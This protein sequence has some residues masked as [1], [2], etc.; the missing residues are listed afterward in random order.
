M[1]TRGTGL[2]VGSSDSAGKFTVYRNAVASWYGPG[3]YGNGVACG[4][5]LSPSTIGVANKTLPC[6][7]KVKF[8]YHGHSVTA[9]VIDRGPYS[10]NREF[11]LTEATKNKLHFPGV[12]TLRPRSRSAP[13]ACE[14][15]G[16]R[17]ALGPSHAWACLDCG[18]GA[19]G[20]EPGGDL[21]GD[22]PAQLELPVP[23]VRGADEPVRDRAP[24]VGRTS[25]ACRWSATPNLGTGRFRIVCSRDGDGS[26]LEETEAIGTPIEVGT[27]SEVGIPE[28]STN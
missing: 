15:A 6:G 1:K 5:T 21:Q 8:R 25:A 17:L 16:R 2:A 9:P 26:E 22:R 14:R 20:Q 10:G 11:D 24:G 18:Y 7:T 12:A 4:G 27:P 28:P 13:S 23:G 19:R 3:L